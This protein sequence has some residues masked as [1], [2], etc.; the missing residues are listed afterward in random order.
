MHFNNYT[1]SKIESNNYNFK[2]QLEIFT[3]NIRFIVKN[4]DILYNKQRDEY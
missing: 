3:N 2:N 4:F 1:I